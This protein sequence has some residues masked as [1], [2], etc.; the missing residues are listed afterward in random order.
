MK[1]FVTRDLKAIF[2]EFLCFWNIFHFFC[3][4][5][6]QRISMSNKMFWSIYGLE[7]QWISIGWHNQAWGQASSDF[8]EETFRRK[9]S[10]VGMIRLTATSK[11]TIVGCHHDPSSFIT[12]FQASFQTLKISE[13]CQFSF[14]K[15]SKIISA[16]QLH[17]KFS[18]SRR[19]QTSFVSSIKLY[20]KTEVKTARLRLKFLI[21]VNHDPPLPTNE[22]FTSQWFI[23]RHIIMRVWAII[24]HKSV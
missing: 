1:K 20:A 15:T 3:F 22:H 11:E 4:N 8:I 5:K 9:L 10:S 18:T 17:H 13:I 12:I 21:S 14:R 16:T 2:C 7:W 24:W 6:N 19:H 23:L